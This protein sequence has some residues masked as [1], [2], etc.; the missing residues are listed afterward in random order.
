MNET[1]K[2]TQS[3]VDAC[4]RNKIRQKLEQD[5]IKREE[6]I[7]TPKELLGF[8]FKITP[9]VV[10]QEQIE[11]RDKEERTGRIES[12]K[13]KMNIPLRHRRLEKFEGEQ[14][15]ARLE[16][17]SKRI[18]NGFILALTGQR[19]TGKTQ[20]AVELIE[21]AVA[22]E[23]SAQYCLAMDFFLKVKATYCQDS[24][25][26][27]GDVIKRF[28]EPKFLVID[29]I[30]E[31]AESQWEDRLMT[32]LFN[33]RYND[34]KDTLLI[35]NLTKGEFIDSVGSSVASRLVETGGICTCN[36]ES[37]RK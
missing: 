5:R 3:E 14:W 28:A 8:V 10:T 24:P 12:L 37:F 19:G 20:M 22:Q 25:E 23:K 11:K 32:H 35:S 21:R 16:Q 33:K 27:E 4:A 7:K 6:N 9:Y 30:Q 17:I 34:V 15:N 36:W 18:G 29:E 31:R 1:Q 26:D 2:Y 13:L